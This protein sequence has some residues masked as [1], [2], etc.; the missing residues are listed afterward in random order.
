MT[1]E[2]TRLLILAPYLDVSHVDRSSLL[3]GLAATCNDRL[4]RNTVS[5]PPVNRAGGAESLL[6]ARRSTKKFMSHS[7]ALSDVAG[8]LWAAT[9]RSDGT[10]RTVPSAH[11]FYPITATLVAT[12]VD[13]LAAGAYEYDPRAHALNV[14]VE[15]DLRHRI[16]SMTLDAQWLIDC[17]SAIVLSA[18]IAASTNRFAQQ[19]STHG[20]RFVWIESGHAAHSVYL[21][22]AHRKLGTCL[23]AGLDD[24]VAA[25]TAGRMIPA[26]HTVLGILPLGHPQK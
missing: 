20:E 11:A 14:R 15:G 9:G 7:V 12:D 2:L 5:L 21:W 6:A 17:P 13:G 23:I 22:A 3:P 1:I 16:A 26:R 18:D 24:D 19:S 8:A 4:V 10:R 25:R